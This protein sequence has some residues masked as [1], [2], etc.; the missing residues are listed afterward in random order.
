V[1]DTARSPAVRRTTAAAS[2]AD[3]LDPLVAALFADGPPVPIVGWDGSTNGAD[4]GA[5]GRVLLRSPDALRQVVWAPGELGLARAYVTG[6]LDVDGDLPAVLHALQDGLRDRKLTTRHVV[7]ALRTAALLGVVGR[8]PAPPPEEARV[9]GRKHSK[10]RDATA[11][12][13]HYDVGNEFYRLV[14]GPSMTYSCAVWSGATPTLEMAQAAKHDLICRKLGLHRT[15]DARLLDV[16][17]GW[18]AMAIHAARH[19]GAR[20]TGITISEEQAYLARHRVAQA[21]LAPL[22]TIRVQDYRDVDDGPYDAI[23]SIG[24]FEH[25]GRARTA[26]Y[27]D[28][29]WR[30][31]APGGRLLNHAISRPGG[32]R[33]GPR[34]FIGRYVFPD[35][36][37][38]D[39][40]D[41]VA[42]METSGFEVRDVEALREHYARTLRAWIANLTTHWEDA[43]AL[44]GERRARVWQLYMAASAVG[45]DD[46]GLGVHQLLGVKP[47][48]NGASGMPWRRDW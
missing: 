30:L 45:F 41:A 7:R 4:P 5:P 40:H 27:F 47:A 18:G 38:I 17:C 42:A 44:V 29:L 6:T 20:V 12:A 1:T 28:R 2:V 22:V 15:T 16:G 33:V 32:S 25:V 9:R 23:S 24:M 10:H 31:L 19:Y 26:E 21:G 46:G 34:S 35:G 8:A 43:V 13:H 11:I 14:L 37:L 39:V 36:E 3:A 48:P